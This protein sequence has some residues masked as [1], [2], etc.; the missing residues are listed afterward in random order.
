MSRLI[1]KVTWKR[2]L[3]LLL[4]AS[5]TSKEI[6]PSAIKKKDFMFQK[7]FT[8]S[9]EDHSWHTIA[10]NLLSLQLPHSFFLSLLW[11][12]ILRVIDHLIKFRPKESDPFH[13]AQEF[14]RKTPPPLFSRTQTH[15]HHQTSPNDCFSQ[16]RKAAIKWYNKLYFVQKG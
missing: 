16:T 11:M 14:R 6:Q 12:W 5:A 15:L 9:K 3:D 8:F 13:T 7:Q 4:S 10:V 1:Q 2:I